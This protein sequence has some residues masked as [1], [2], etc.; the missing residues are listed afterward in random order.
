L[1]VGDGPGILFT[2]RVTLGT[3]RMSIER[4]YHRSG[5]PSK[6]GMAESVH[7]SVCRQIVNHEDIDEN[8]E[9]L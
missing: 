5:T 6:A 8:I 9:L 2:A 4:R 1:S 7:K 3:A